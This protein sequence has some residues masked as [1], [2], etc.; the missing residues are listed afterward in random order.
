MVDELELL[1]SDNEELDRALVT[2]G[3]CTVN[4]LDSLLAVGLDGMATDCEELEIA[5]TF[6]LED[7]GGVW[8]C[9]VGL[10][11]LL[12]IVEVVLVN[13]TEDE[14]VVA[15]GYKNAFAGFADR[16]TLLS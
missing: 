14:N 11:E 8:I 12:R 3:F 4:V 13:R 2:S 7:V 5:A 9:R 10:D 15:L 1:K 6:W 16:L